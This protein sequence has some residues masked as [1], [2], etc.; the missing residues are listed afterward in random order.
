MGASTA[1]IFSKR[2]R[3]LGAGLML[4]AFLGAA[5]PVAAQKPRTDARGEEPGLEQKRVQPKPSQPSAALYFCR[6]ADRQCRSRENE[7]R[8]DEVRD[9]FVLVAWRNVAGEHT[10]QVRFLLPDGNPYQ[11]ITSKFGA[12]TAAG[13]DKARTVLPA[14]SA[15]VVMESLA[16]A[17]THISQ[18]SLTGNWVV[19]VYLDGTQITRR[20]LTLL[21]RGQN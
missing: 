12:P 6:V 17:G 7:F 10:Q 8:L 19:E 11:V 4:L 18:R 13:Q 16:V 3:W 14:G 1:S 5:A 15:S 2:P 21:P 9:L 20:E